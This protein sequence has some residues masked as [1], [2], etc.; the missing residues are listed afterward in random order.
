MTMLTDCHPPVGSPFSVAAGPQTYA[1]N[2]GPDGKIMG[3]NKLIYGKICVILCLTK[4]KE[5]W[6]Q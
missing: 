1:R 2:G 5:T 3:G 6:R 4:T